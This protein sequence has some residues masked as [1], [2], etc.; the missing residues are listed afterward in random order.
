[1]ERRVNYYFLEAAAVGREARHL[2]KHGQHGNV[3]PG[4]CL[5]VPLI[6]SASQQMT[7]CAPV[8]LVWPFATSGRTESGFRGAA[9]VW[10]RPRHV[11]H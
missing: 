3:W 8:T 9:D 6:P 1:M 5:P 4:R 7:D 11:A 2:S 10:R